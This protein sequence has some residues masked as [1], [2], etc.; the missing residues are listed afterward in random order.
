[1]E[2]CHLRGVRVGVSACV[3]MRASTYTFERA[4]VHRERSSL[5]HRECRAPWV[6]VLNRLSAIGSERSLTC[7]QA[8][9]RALLACMLSLC[10]RAPWTCVHPERACTLNVRAPWKCVHPERACTLSMCALAC[11]TASGRVAFFTASTY[12]HNAH[13]CVWL[14][15]L[16]SSRVIWACVRACWRLGVQ[17]ASGIFYEK[18]Q[19]VLG[20]TLCCCCFGL[21]RN[22]SRSYL[23]SPKM[24]SATPATSSVYPAFLAFLGVKQAII[25]AFPFWKGQCL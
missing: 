19:G 10:L 11:F 9:M 7:V 17:A 5:V 4:R 18:I 2:I 8:C 25:Q 22:S 1:M 21:P 13:I 15:A 3:S 14:F 16:H 24:G 23:G 12:M 20:K 6:S